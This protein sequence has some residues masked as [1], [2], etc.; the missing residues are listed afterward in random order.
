MARARHDTSTR[1]GP[2][3]RRT[4]S[5]AVV[6]DDPTRKDSRRT[7]RRR[8]HNTALTRLGRGAL[9]A[10]LLRGGRTLLLASL[11]KLRQLCA[12]L[13]LGRAAGHRPV[14]VALR[15]RLDHGFRRG[16][17][18]VLAHAAQLLVDDRL[19]HGAFDHGRDL[20]CGWGKGEKGTDTSV[21]EFCGVLWSNTRCFVQGV[22]G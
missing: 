5:T 19:R 21:C 7:G 3:T 13:R 8:V 4:C 20:P 14:D 1:A 12:R 22:S 2:Q 15:R 17:L 9:H 10:G 16:R 6:H 11:E 18:G